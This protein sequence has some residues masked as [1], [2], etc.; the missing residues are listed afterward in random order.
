M[1]AN[2]AS[3]G[4]LRERYKVALLCGEDLAVP[5]WSCATGITEFNERSIVNWPVQATG[6]DILRL[7]V[8]WATRRGLR[9]LAPV[10][11][12]ILLDALLDRIEHDVALLQEIMRRA[13]RVVLN[14]TATGNL[15]LR[16]D[17]TIVRF[18]ARFEDPHGEA[19]WVRVLELLVERRR[20]QKQEAAHG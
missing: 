7:A 6:A 1:E 12:A 13:S 17:A 19:I 16:A 9:L 4:A 5:G 8:V 10:H 15:A 18:P 3:H 20:R 14:D 11:D 2:K